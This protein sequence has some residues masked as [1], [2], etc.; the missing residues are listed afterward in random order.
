MSNI[1]FNEYQRLAATTA[2]Y[3]PLPQYRL[4]N[5]AMGLCGEVGEFSELI[6]K[7]VFHSKELDK[8]KCLKE[9]GDV[10]WYLAI[11]AKELDISL[12]DIATANIA[13][14]AARYPK[15]FIPGGGVRD[16]QKA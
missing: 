16:E 6:K 14:L 11:V 9:L 5:W 2:N 1:D 7:H 13:K 8:D 10:M 4:C 15:G 12:Q 3:D